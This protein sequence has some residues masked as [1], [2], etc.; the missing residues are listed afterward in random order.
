M[1]ESKTRDQWQSPGSGEGPTGGTSSMCGEGMMRRMAEA[2]G[3]GPT[4]AERAPSQEQSGAPI[5]ASDAGC[6]GG[7]DTGVGA[8]PGG[9][10]EDVT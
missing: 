6:C 10:G 1:S 2:C 5:D 8:G 3:C 4:M 7:G 9:Q